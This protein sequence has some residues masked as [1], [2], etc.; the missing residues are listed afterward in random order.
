LRE[1][2]AA[3][4]GEDAAPGRAVE[5]AAESLR[6]G[7]G[8]GAGAVSLPSSPVAAAVSAPPL[9]AVYTTN[10]RHAV[11]N[12]PWPNIDR[13]SQ[14]YRELGSDP[15]SKTFRE[16]EAELALLMEEA[17]RWRGAIRDP[18]GAGDFIVDGVVWDVKGFV[19][20]F[21]PRKGG[22]VLAKSIRIIR[23]ELE[24]GRSVVVDTRRMSDLD[25][26]LLAREVAR[27]VLVEP[28]MSKVVFFP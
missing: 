8:Q 20:E 25:V 9:A 4:V 17:G 10:Y 5:A 12:D 15:A 23:D 28:L 16:A 2:D 18:S 27:L 24:A 26:N 7:G 22:F 6:R 13:K 11:P 3:D 21:K 19:S 1:L 14:R